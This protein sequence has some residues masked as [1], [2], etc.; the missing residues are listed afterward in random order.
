MLA[1]KS[2]QKIST[3]VS[4]ETAVYLR[5]LIRKGAAENLA[6]ALD[7]VIDRARRLENRARLAEDT[8]AYFATLPHPV[9]SAES[10]A[11]RLPNPAFKDKDLLLES[12]LAALADEVDFDR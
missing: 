4:H 6:E 12:S 1:K 7:R 3:T 5:S 11:M 8:A 2:R 10:G 9:T